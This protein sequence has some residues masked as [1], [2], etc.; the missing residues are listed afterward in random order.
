MIRV[1][2]VVGLSALCVF[3]CVCV[4]ICVCVHMW[5]CAVLLSRRLVSCV[6]VHVVYEVS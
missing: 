6:N 5:V 1:V 3:V 2:S 4:F